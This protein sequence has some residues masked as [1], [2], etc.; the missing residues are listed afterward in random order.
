[1]TLQGNNFDKNEETTRKLAGFLAER[2]RHVVVVEEGKH[3][4]PEMALPRRWRALYGLE[5]HGVEIL[6]ECK[7]AEIN[8]THVAVT[9]REGEKRE[10]AGQSVILASGTHANRSLYDELA[11]ASCE[12]RIIG[13][14][15]RIGYI[16]G[17][18]S[19]AARVAREI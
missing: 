17:A 18:M 13:D 12:L 11:G 1:M 16:D 19:S 15:D 9:T 10:I 3:L 6:R 2:D 5:E 14:A 7:V 8:A 4:A